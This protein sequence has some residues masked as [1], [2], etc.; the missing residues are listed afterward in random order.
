MKTRSKT[1]KVTILMVSLFLIGGLLFVS[2]PNEK[3]M[4]RDVS[5]LILAK[6]AFAQTGEASFLEQEA[7]I[8][9]YVNVGQT[10]DLARA[11]GSYRTVEKETESYVVGSVALPEYPASEDVH[12]YIH[13]DGWVVAY[14]MKDEPASKIVD[15]LNYSSGNVPT[16]LELVV[17]M[18]GSSLGLAIT[19]L[20]Y[21]H[22]NYPNAN[23]LTIIVKT[24]E[25]AEKRS[26]TE[27]F[28]ITIPSGLPVYERAWFLYAYERP[29]YSGGDATLSIDGKQ[30][31]ELDLGFWFSPT[32]SKFAYGT[33][34]VAQ[35]ATDVKNTLSLYWDNPYA[36]TG[37]TLVYQEE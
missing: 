16:K 28:K 19:N 36:R 18:M 21:Y 2:V 37:I 27:I 17:D 10:I 1:T 26:G 30:I 29:K 11:K 15:W 9:A 22:F 31:Y 12:V 23:K 32:P 14:Y 34:S 5:G 8:A 20:K 6:P 7:G 4:T 13:Q 35:L 24:N 33:L 25:A 3:S